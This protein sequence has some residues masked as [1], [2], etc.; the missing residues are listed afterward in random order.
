MIEKKEVSKSK[1]LPI[2]L[3]LIIAGFLVFILA[4]TAFKLHPYNVTPFFN[5]INE[6]ATQQY[7]L[8]LNVSLA[9]AVQIR[10]FNV[11]LPDGFSF[12][13]KSNA[14]N[15]SAN[16]L[17]S[18]T[19]TMLSW[20][21]LSADFLV[22]YST[23]KT[24]F[25]F[26]ATAANPGFYNFTVALLNC[27]GTL[28]N[29]VYV[30]V[31][32]NITDT[33]PPD[34][35]AGNISLIANG[36]NYSGTIILNVSLFDNFQGGVPARKVYF[37]ITNSTAGVQQNITDA[38]NYT[39]N[40]WNA[41][42]DTAT[43]GDGFYNITIWANDSTQNLNNS[44]YLI[45]RIDNTP[46]VASMT[47]TPTT[48]D[49][50][51]TITCNCVPSD[52]GSGVNSSL[53]SYTV[54]P[55]TTKTGTFTQT[56]SFG[57]NAGK[58]GTTTSNTYSVTMTGAPPSSSGP[59]SK[60]TVKKAVIP[61]IVPGTTKVVTTIDSSTNVKDIEIEVSSTASNVQIT[62][63]NY[64]SKPTAVSVEKGDAYKYIQ[65]NTVNLA[66]KLSKAVMRIYVPKSWVST[67]GIAKEDVALF[68]YDSTANKWNELTTTYESEDSSNY[69]YTVQLT[70]FSYFAIAQKETA[71]SGGEETSA[72]SGEET[73]VTEFPIWAW[74]VIGI[75]IV[76]AIVGGGFA[77]KKRR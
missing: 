49:V 67:E 58:T 51:D 20:V 41:T 72:P 35:Y 45:I 28:C 3:F 57:D 76:A 39:A 60:P 40:V 32:V 69:Y 24:N 23:N 19:S 42:F 64:N 75:I 50:G 5:T 27:S 48:V 54:N 13:Y 16:F 18:N 73:P 2:F 53:T 55:T 61:E 1:F 66:D 77:L 14:T 52:S 62:V 12:L 71:V 74:V 68:K 26:N 11:T 43:L 63:S 6:D 30:N 33:T 46:P 4:D 56:C 31:S 22:N 15:N 21:N 9:P 17:F 65:V 44:A 37:N 25:K 47:C 8:S 38:F 70:S 10:Q 7:N 29:A 59:S 36:G 34:V